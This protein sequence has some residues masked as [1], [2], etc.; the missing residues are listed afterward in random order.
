MKWMSLILG[1]VLWS[2]AMPLM[3]QAE[4]PVEYG[5]LLDR[6]SL[7]LEGKLYEYPPA[8]R[9][10]I[11]GG[12]EGDKLKVQISGREFEIPASQIT[13]DSSV[14]QALLTKMAEDKKKASRLSKVMAERPSGAAASDKLSAEKL[15]ALQKQEVQLRS[16][17]E[18]VRN[19][20]RN[21][22][23]KLKPWSQMDYV[24]NAHHNDLKTQLANLEGQ[25]SKVMDQERGLREEMKSEQAAK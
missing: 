8:M 7:P 13:R 1:A 19:E 15:A 6:V 23:F 20:M 2:G 16:Q 17:M 14:A 12:S 25:H 9:V 11:V 24:N 22:P 5:Y 18:R 3:A 21:T 4:M 10:V